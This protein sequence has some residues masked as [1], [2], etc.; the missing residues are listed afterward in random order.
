[1]SIARV[2]MH[3]YVEENFYQGVDAL[4]QT[5]RKDTFHQLNKL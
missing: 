1:M 2:T 5:V 3:E 4:Y